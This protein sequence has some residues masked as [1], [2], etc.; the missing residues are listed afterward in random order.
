[1][2]GSAKPW[3]GVSDGVIAS[4]RQTRLDLGD[5]LTR[6]A[7]DLVL[8]WAQHVVRL[9]S[10]A[11]GAT[12]AE[13]AWNAWDYVAALVLRELCEI[14]RVNGSTAGVDAVRI[15]AATDDLLRSFTEDDPRGVVR[16]FADDDAGAGWWWSRIPTSG[17]VRA[18]LDGWAARVR[19]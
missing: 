5:G 19:W 13:L 15:V 18:E 14:H 7:A 11:A 1:M 9:K 4:L 6:S 2:T 8:G 10:E 17:P 3:D 16:R 12:S